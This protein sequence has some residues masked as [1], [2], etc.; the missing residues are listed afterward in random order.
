MKSHKDSCASVTTGK[1]QVKKR[2]TISELRR[3]QEAQSYHMYK[4]SH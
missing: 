2:I 3:K 1:A 4:T